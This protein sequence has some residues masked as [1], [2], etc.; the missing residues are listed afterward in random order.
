M[1]RPLVVFLQTKVMMSTT[2]TSPGLAV[3][4]GGADWPFQFEW[5]PLRHLFIDERYQRPPS[6]QVKKIVEEFDAA[7]VGTLLGSRRSKTKLAVIDGQHRFLAMRQLGLQY[8]PLM[9]A[10]KL[11]LRD[12]ARLFARL[13]RERLSIRPVQRFRAELAGE[14]ERPMQI[15]TVLD[16][17]EL[18]ITDSSGRAAG[19]RSIGAV[20]A[21]E[22]LWDRGGASYVERVLRI[23][24]DAWDGQVMSFSNEIIRGLDYFLA[25]HDNVDD[26]RLAYRLRDVTPMLVT[27]RASGLR[28]GRGLGGKSPSYM[29]EI[30]A[31]EYRRRRPVQ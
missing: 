16:R 13:Q 23:V 3:V 7:M 9:V 30:I 5:V 11:P 24:L 26:D 10:E 21:L 19:S 2:A 4:P 31:S 22:D 1:R 29:A 8:A 25:Q 20:K 18:E 12:E 17:L 27:H 6:R 15:Q 28:A 14:L